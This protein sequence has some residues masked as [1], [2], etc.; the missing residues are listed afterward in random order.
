VSIADDAVTRIVAASGGSPTPEHL[1]SYRWLASAAAGV[2]YGRPAPPL[3]NLPATWARSS[4]E[5]SIAEGWIDD[6]NFAMFGY[7][8]AEA[9][10]KRFKAG[11]PAALAEVAAWLLGTLPGIA[12]TLQ[13][14][15]CEYVLTPP[16]HTAGRA[17]GSAEALCATLAEAFPWLGYLRG[18]LLRSE[19][20][21][22]R[23]HDGV[24]PGFDRHFE[25]I[26][27]IGPR[28]RNAVGRAALLIDDVYRDGAT[29]AACRQVLQDTLGVNRV[30]ALFITRTSAGWPPSS[31]VK[32]VEMR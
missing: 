3:P 5:T 17:R 1:T 13:A 21:T 10:V 22:S 12:S 26:R 28:P 2:R 23:Y 27:Y 11:E 29:S 30:F 14:A 8:R 24:A 7:W 18:A 4:F 25:T 16:G 19:T 9:M 6:D 31:A 20:V 32:L 15:D